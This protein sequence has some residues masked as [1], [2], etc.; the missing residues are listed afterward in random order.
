MKLGSSITVPPRLGHIAA[1]VLVNAHVMKRSTA[2][3]TC[4][5][6]EN[7]MVLHCHA[8]ATCLTDEWM[9]GADFG[10]VRASPAEAHAS[11]AAIQ[12]THVRAIDAH[13]TYSLACGPTISKGQGMAFPALLPMTLRTLYGPNINDYVRQFLVSELN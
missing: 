1:Y 9:E 13:P 11:E 2:T 3:N 6:I 8:L 12:K 5:L 7:W 4:T 10:R